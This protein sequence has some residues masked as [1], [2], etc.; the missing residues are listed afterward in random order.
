MMSKI[1]RTIYLFIFC[2]VFSSCKLAPTK[3]H[4]K[5]SVLKN[6]S[7]AGEIL[8][9]E[10]V[11]IDA[12]SSFDYHLAHIPQS[13]SLQWTDFTQKDPHYR[14]LLED[15]YFGQ[16]RRLARIGIHRDS[17][18]TIVG[19]GKKG[20]GEEGRLAWNLTFLGV[21]KIKISSIDQ[22]KLKSSEMNVEKPLALE[23]PMPSQTLWKPKTDE[24]LKVD[25]KKFLEK[26]KLR[27][28]SAIQNVVFIDARSEREY[29][30]S[31]PPASMTHLNLINIPWKEFLNDRGELNAEIKDRLKSVSISD[32]KEIIVLDD[33]GV[34][35]GLVVFALRQLGYK[36][37]AILEGGYRALES[38]N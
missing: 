6:E 35:S 27:N 11:I 32:E 19:N 15:D 23:E 12:R 17:E 24:T 13:I 33:E 1:G 36:K 3:I 9:T 2:L 34:G 30:Q 26:T 7:V 5:K 8:K 4:E 38:A 20:S 28:P 16:A 25:R 31:T 10:G 29:L 22:W 37:S 21:Q 14:G 18:V